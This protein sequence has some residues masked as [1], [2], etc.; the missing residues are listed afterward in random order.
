MVSIVQSTKINFSLGTI[1]FILRMCVRGNKF[2]AY[3]LLFQNNIIGANFDAVPELILAWMDYTLKI[4][5]FY[6]LSLK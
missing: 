6:S 2:T 4:N 1:D 3:K 5:M